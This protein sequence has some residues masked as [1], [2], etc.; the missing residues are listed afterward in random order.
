MV[1][2]LALL[3]HVVP[4]CSTAFEHTL[5]SLTGDDVVHAVVIPVVGGFSYRIEGREDAL[6]IVVLGIDSLIKRSAEAIAVVVDYILEVA[7]SGGHISRICSMVAGRHLTAPHVNLACKHFR[8]RLI[9]VVH[10]LV[11]VENAIGVAATGIE[12]ADRSL[13]VALDL[14]EKIFGLAAGHLE[15]VVVI[16]AKH[17]IGGC[18]ERAGAVDLVHLRKHKLMP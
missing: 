10:T 2:R 8:S 11:G 17:H 7:L 18:A 5:R 14:I 4:S 3:D 13:H 15:G 16:V 9:P 6:G 1:E 12:V